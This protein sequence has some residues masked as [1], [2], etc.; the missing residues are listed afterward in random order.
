MYILI[1]NPERVECENEVV[2]KCEAEG[3][4]F[5]IYN[6]NLV[7][8]R[9]GRAVSRYR[10]YNL[11]NEGP[12]TSVPPH[13]V[14]TYFD[15]DFGVKIGHVVCFDL[16]FEK[17]ALKLVREHN[18]TDVIHPSHWVS[19]GPMTY[20]VE[21]QSAWAYENDVNLLATGGDD[22]M[23][24]GGGNNFFFCIQVLHNFEGLFLL[25]DN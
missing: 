16:V 23:T 3:K 18:V 17:P 20:S 4:D 15:T 14:P 10:K 19:S 1:N 5:I 12:V 9:E 8:D 11:F 24:S 13:P 25:C 7:F 2:E 22:P 21:F 6:T